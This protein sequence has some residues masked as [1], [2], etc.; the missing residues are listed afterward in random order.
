MA[1]GAPARRFLQSSTHMREACL[2]A[3][4]TLLSRRS[5]Q[6]DPETS[7]PG[8][9]A[10]YHLLE[11]MTLVGFV[12]QNPITVRRTSTFLRG[13]LFHFHPGLVIGGRDDAAQRMQQRCPRSLASRAPVHPITAFT[14]PRSPPLCSRAKPGNCGQARACRPRALIRRSRGRL[15]IARHP[16]NKIPSQ[17]SPCREM[18]LLRTKVLLW[19]V[20]QNCADRPRCAASRARFHL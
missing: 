5:L 17:G 15:L 13:L 11:N 8:T 20:R 10:H 16:K 6:R 1:A 7:F 4:C 12:S 2:L 18:P 19:F 14:G 9:Y 3:I